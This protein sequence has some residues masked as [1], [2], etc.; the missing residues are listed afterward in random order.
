MNMQKYTYIMHV[1]VPVS[2]SHIPESPDLNDATFRR[3][4]EPGYGQQK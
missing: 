4:V 3:Y 2:E 1:F